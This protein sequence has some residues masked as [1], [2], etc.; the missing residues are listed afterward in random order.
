MIPRELVLGTLCLFP[1]SEIVLGLL[2][3][4]N[5]KE[6]SV[7]DQGTLRVIWVVVSVSVVIASIVKNVP[8]TRLPIPV[9]LSNML[10]ITL[11]IS[12]LALRWLSILTLGRYFTVN[13]AI[14]PDQHVV[15]SGPYRFIRHP[16]YTGMLIAFLG[17][18]MYFANWLSLL[19][20][21]FPITVATLYR[22]KKEEEILL[23]VLGPPYQ[24]YCMKTKR[25]IPWLY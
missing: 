18:G 2:K 11:T 22:I 24:A 21:L 1:I 15:T 8:S 23:N 7:H 25:L 12:G 14:H 4:A 3:R 6:S 9:D 5:S 10:S 20:L 17:L 19:F 16:S 13:V